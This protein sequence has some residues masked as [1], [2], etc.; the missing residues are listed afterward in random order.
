MQQTPD[1]PAPVRGVGRLLV[2]GGDAE[3]F[4]QGQLTQ[5]LKRLR[6]G[7]RLLAGYC[8]AK[9]RLLAVLQIERAADGFALELHRSVLEQTLKRLRMFVL[10]SR[11]TLAAAP[12]VVVPEERDEA[13]RRS[14]IESGIPTI[15]PATS[16]HFVPQMCNLDLLGAISFDKG[17]YTGQEI[18]ARLHYLGQV[19]RRMFRTR[20]ASLAQPGEPIFDAAGDAQAVG[21][22]VDAVPDNAGS[23]ALV[24]LQTSH[25]GG[26]LRL[27][28]P[29]GAVLTAL[30]P[31]AG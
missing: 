17:C 12:D 2:S 10:R 5:D 9:G 26:D 30:T 21:E 20:I 3:G 23:L 11:V 24:V 22:V 25:A 29:Q 13:W 1:A 16:D 31:L 28:S 7:D 18:V 19:K 4:L 14:R 15:F 6:E 27:A 8:S